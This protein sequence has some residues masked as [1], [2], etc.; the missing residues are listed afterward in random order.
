MNN[1]VLNS[2]QI[3]HWLADAEQVLRIGAAESEEY[4][5]A[6]KISALAKAM[7]SNT[8]DS[9]RVMAWLIDADL[10]LQA[11]DEI[12]EEYAAAE[13]I[14]AL[15]KSVLGSGYELRLR[16]REPVGY[17]IGTV[18]RENLTQAI[19]CRA[20]TD[21]EIEPLCT[22]SLCLPAAW[23][24]ADNPPDVPRGEFLDCWVA[25]HFRERDHAAGP[26]QYKS[27]RPLVLLA[28]WGGVELLRGKEGGWSVVDMP[29]GTFTPRAWQPI[30]KPA[31]PPEA[32]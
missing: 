23:H 32:L 10:I 8:L 16:S 28:R 24:P 27:V 17:R 11:R 25:G 21:L 22:V 30:A 2:K 26:G 31:Y 20:D 4:A 9:Q 19:A 13:K 12:G 6:K 5:A 1:D 15:A 29:D 7:Q 18:L 14:S 3:A